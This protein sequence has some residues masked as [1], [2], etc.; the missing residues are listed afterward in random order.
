MKPI[1][2]FKLVGLFL[3]LMFA[4]MAQAKNEMQLIDSIVAVVNDQVITHKELN[5]RVELI[6]NQA[7][8]ENTSLPS[9]D[10]L[11]QQVLDSMITEKL[12]L[13]L[14]RRNHID[15]SPDSVNQQLQKLAQSNNMT[16][17]QF[18]NE[19]QR[20]GIDYKQFRDRLHKQMI[21]QKMQHQA[22]APQINITEQQIRSFMDNYQQKPHA[23]SNYHLADIVIPL[24][25]EPTQAQVDK[26]RKKAE[27][28]KHKLAKGSDFHK[29]AVAESQGSNALQGG[30]M[31]WNRL[32][33]LPD[34]FAKH[35]VTMQQGDIAGPIKAPNGFHLIKLKEIKQS[36]SKLTKEKARK[37]LFQRQFRQKLDNWLDKSKKQAYIKIVLYD[38]Q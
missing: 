6:S 3:C 4:T 22:L 26:A 12:Q 32:G 17:L 16:L 21:I 5:D 25:D 31:G 9:K 19:L 30:D 11:K 23:D 38:E 35:L 27:Q 20:R 33:E 28:I 14:A 13:Q 24:P 1:V 36:K 29:L 18:K 15:V 10:K 37:M 7:S 8:S 2:R 34:V